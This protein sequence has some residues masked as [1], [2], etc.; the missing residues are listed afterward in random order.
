MCEFTATA[1]SF[2]KGFAMDGKKRRSLMA[3]A[4]SE[5]VRVGREFEQQIR[6]A[7][8]DRGL[9][10]LGSNIHFGRDEVDLL[11]LDGTTCVIVEVRGRTNESTDTVLL[12]TAQNRKKL[13][14]LKRVALKVLQRYE[15]AAAV[16][17][18]LA[19]IGYDGIEILE[20]AIDFSLR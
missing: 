13:K 20:N 14:F 6:S 15:D 5:R 8:E 19:V 1:I 3:T 16:R 12:Q 11:A 9:I 7:I 18:D 17:I 4:P 2:A 10:V